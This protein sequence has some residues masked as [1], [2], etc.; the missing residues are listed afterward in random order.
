MSSILRVGLSSI[1]HVV[2]A[3]CVFRPVAGTIRGY[4]DKSAKEGDIFSD[5]SI[6]KRHRDQSPPLPETRASPTT[7]PTPQLFS[8]KGRTVAITGGGRGVGITLAA[9]VL[10][11]GGNAACIDM[12]SEPSPKEWQILQ[13]KAS[14]TGQSITYHNCDIT[15]E[16][17]LAEVVDSIAKEAKSRDAPLR[18]VVACAGIQQTMDAIDY[19][20]EDFRKILDVNVTGAFLTVK[21]C[22]R[23]FR[24]QGEGGSVV[25][26]ASMSGQIANRVC[27]SRWHKTGFTDD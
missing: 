17:R 10:E 3:R 4:A 7:A 19:K 11:A 24:E 21:H 8:L 22:A 16:P 23:H 1:R 26:V 6:P 27:Y 2:R 5:Q 13:E 15:Q 18:G 12:L 14:S 25:L 20:V 9:A